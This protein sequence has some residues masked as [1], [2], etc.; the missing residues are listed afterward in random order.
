MIE[1]KR[2]EEE[3]DMERKYKDRITE[4]SEEEKRRRQKRGRTVG[5]REGKWAGKDG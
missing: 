1:G 2:E 4:K 3:G 5:R